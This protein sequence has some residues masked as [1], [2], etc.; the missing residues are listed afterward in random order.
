MIQEN[1]ISSWKTDFEFPLVSILCDVFNHENFLKE[2]LDGF[3]SQKTTFP[4]EIIVH[5]DASTDNSR[6]IIKQYQENFPLIIKPI[7]QTVNQFSQ[8]KTKIWC[9]YT[10]PKA[11]GKYIALCEGDDYWIATDKLQKQVDFLENNS[12][13]SIVWTN[14]KSKSGDGFIENDFEKTLD[15]SVTITFD[16]LFAPYCTYTLTSLFRKDSVDIRKY[17]ELNH[18]K[19]NT[20][21]SLALCNGKGMFLN[22]KSAV[23]RWHSGGIF[24][25]KG[26]FFK[27]Y[28]SYLNLKEIYDEIPQART[29]N[30][31]YHVNSLLKESAKEALK[32]YVT[33]DDFN[34]EHRSVIKTYLSEV[35]F[36]QR[37]KFLK[38]YIKMRY[39]KKIM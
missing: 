4:F 3:L 1:V 20:L 13:Y 31:K 17:N 14:F 21:F 7:F 10:F 6:A 9:E 16:N 26:D 2:T 32:L 38:R 15:S 19:D 11:K 30:M 22:F 37:L 33:K 12:E 34:T 35:S 18:S 24:S 27:R 5:D 25:L 36:F 29:K 28:S 23:Y 39:L 8:R